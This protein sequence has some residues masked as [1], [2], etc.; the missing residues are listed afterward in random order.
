MRMDS[1]P[2]YDVDS[3]SIRSVVFD[4]GFELLNPGP[5]TVGHVRTYIESILPIQES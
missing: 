1:V 3:G 2:M 5:V 4:T